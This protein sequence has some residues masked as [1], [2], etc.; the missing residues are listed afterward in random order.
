MLDRKLPEYVLVTSSCGSVCKAHCRSG[1]DG[2]LYLKWLGLN[3]DAPV[4][5]CFLIEQVLTEVLNG[6]EPL[7]WISPAACEHGSHLSWVFSYGLWHSVY[8][9][10]LSWELAV[11]A[12]DLDLEQRLIEN[13]DFH[14]VSLGEVLSHRM[15]IAVVISEEGGNR[16]L[17]EDDVHH[18]VG[19]LD[20]PSAN[21]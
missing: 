12:V 7:L 20:A 13:F 3:D 11:F 19:L 9:T 15:F 1:Q 10:E 18:N 2:G 16:S 17:V 8:H 21:D 14:G 5:E 4:F 6:L